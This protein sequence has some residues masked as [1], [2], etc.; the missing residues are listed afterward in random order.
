MEHGFNRSKDNA[1]LCSTCGRDWISHTPAATCE[2]CKKT[3]SCNII[4]NLLLCVDCFT[5]HEKQLKEEITSAQDYINPIIAKARELDMNMST[6]GYFF[7]ADTVSHK[8]IKDA[9]DNDDT[10]PNEDKKNR[11]FQEMVRRFESF[12]A[13][14][15]AFDDAIHNATKAKEERVE[16]QLAIANTLRT[17]GNEVRKEI[18]DKIRESD[19]FYKPIEVTKKIS[20]PK[21]KK[22][23]VSPFE[24]MAEQVSL[25]KNITLA[26]A[27]R[28][29][30]ENGMMPE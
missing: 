17:Y 23:S 10:I 1:L 7:N 29:L 19:S 15:V 5:T 13:D 2:K 8:E 22:V 24:R 6:A 20:S 25:N 21:V 27:K 4:E 12:Q 3:R 16:R 11:F 14:I 9:I 26:E 30:I 18:R 28:Q